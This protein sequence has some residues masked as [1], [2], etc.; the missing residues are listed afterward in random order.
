MDLRLKMRPQPWN[1][2]RTPFLP[3][4]QTLIFFPAQTAY[5][6]DLHHEQLQR[7][8][9]EE[10]LDR[11]A[12]HEDEVKN[13]KLKVYQPVRTLVPIRNSSEF[14]LLCVVT[15][16]WFVRSSSLAEVVLPNLRFALLEMTA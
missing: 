16:T 10:A 3:A 9:G 7:R 11:L 13:T 8:I 6:L 14:A 15:L 4:D 12:W 2:H 5:Q 1:L